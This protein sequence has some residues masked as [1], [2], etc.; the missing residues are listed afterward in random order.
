MA[1]LTPSR[2]LPVQTCAGV[3]PAVRSRRHHVLRGGRERRYSAIVM[4][5]GIVVSM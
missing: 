5:A 1:L 2:L 4:D 3:E